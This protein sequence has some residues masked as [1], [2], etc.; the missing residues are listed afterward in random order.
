M[1]HKYAVDWHKYADWQQKEHH[2]AA[3]TKKNPNKFEE[4]TDAQPLKPKLITEVFKQVLLHIPS[5]PIGT[6]FILMS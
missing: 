6:L 1:K 3:K 4:S 2:L 5:M